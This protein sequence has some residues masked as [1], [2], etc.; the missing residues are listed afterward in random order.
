MTEQ[1][2]QQAGGAST[3]SIAIT[4]TEYTNVSNGNLNCALFLMNRQRV[5]C[6]VGGI[7]PD[8]ETVDCFTAGGGA[9]YEYDGRRM[10][11]FL[12]NLE[13]ED[14]LW[15]RSEEADEAVTVVRGMMRVGVL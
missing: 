5:R 1:P 13:G 15:V 10:S 11:L 9:P 7:Q 6:H 14:E 3:H 2:I 4:P 12:E 8:P